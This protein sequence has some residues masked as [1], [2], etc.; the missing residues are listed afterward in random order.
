VAL[1]KMVGFEESFSSSRSSGTPYIFFFNVPD[2]LGVHFSSFG[3]LVSTFLFGLGL[4]VLLFL[5]KGGRGS[6]LLWVCTPPGLFLF[7][8]PSKARD[9]GESQRLRLLRGRGG[10]PIC[11][12]FALSSSASLSTLL[13]ALC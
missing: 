5:L 11:V 10:G 13:A 2:F 3:K 1:L 6:V 12:F 4:S 8:S 7:L 9:R